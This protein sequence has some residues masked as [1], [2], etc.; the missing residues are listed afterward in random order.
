MLVLLYLSLPSLIIPFPS[1]FILL[2]L[3]RFSLL[4][5]AFS[6]LLLFLFLALP[7]PSPFRPSLFSPPLFLIF[8]T[9]LSCFPVFSSIQFSFFHSFSS[10][11]SLSHLSLPLASFTLH[12]LPPSLTQFFS[13]PLTLLF[14]QHIILSLYSPL[15][16]SV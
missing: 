7:L 3:F 12:V 5:F 16:L 9:F 13:S 8:P 14:P 15:F 10:S 6:L 11:S 4:S 1:L 2:P